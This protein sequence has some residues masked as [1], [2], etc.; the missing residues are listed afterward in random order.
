[1]KSALSRRL[2]SPGFLAFLRTEVARRLAR[3]SGYSLRALA[4]RLKMDH[5]SL[6][7]VLRGRRRLTPRLVRAIGA[8]LGL[9]DPQIEEYVAGLDLEHARG[10]R[11]ALR[12]LARDTSEILGDWLHFAILELTRL[13]TFR[14]DVRWIASTLRV[15]CDEVNA[16]TSR[17]ARLRM[18]SLAGDRWKDL[19]GDVEAN[20]DHFTEAA[21]RQFTAQARALA[22]HARAGPAAG[23]GTMSVTTMAIERCALP[24]AIRRM[25]QLREELL[26]MLAPGDRPEMLV[27]LE[28]HLIPLTSSDPGGTKE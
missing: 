28:L 7:Q 19:S 23:E 21:L 25:E 13:K 24:R 1:M 17:L 9:R 22:W 10:T 16:A 11:P 18:L 15:T 8:G 6:S 3:S 5:S 26:S 4:Q 27:Q 20:A 12:S 2:P 14:A